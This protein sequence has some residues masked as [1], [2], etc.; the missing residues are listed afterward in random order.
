LDCPA[1]SKDLETR[2]V[3][4]TPFSGA[5]AAGAEQSVIQ[6]PGLP[7][8]AYRLSEGEALMPLVPA[9]AK[10]KWMDITSERSGYHCLPMVIANQAGWFILSAHSLRVRWSGGDDVDALRI[11][12]LSGEK[13]YPAVSI[14]GRGILTFQIPYLFRTPPGYNTL[15]RGPANLPKDGAFPLE[16]IVE[17]DWAVA[18]FTMNWQIT[19]ANQT[20]S[21]QKDEPIAM[22]VPQL[23]GNLEQFRPRFESIG[24]DA[25]SARGY[26]QWARS[27]RQFINSRRT[28]PAETAGTW[29]DHYLRGTCPDGIRAPEHQTALQLHPFRGVVENADRNEHV[30]KVANDDGPVLK[31]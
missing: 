4:A 30:I 12:Y 17:T 21:F 24:A 16:G 5:E 29:Q 18:T 28:W 19:R 22:I 15:V 25:E 27:R 8:V 7:L 23:R 9:P 13:P 3:A 26:S 14:F 31:S 2:R 11:F 10:R 6:H 1:S 20:V